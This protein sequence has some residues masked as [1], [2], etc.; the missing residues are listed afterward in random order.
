MIVT[1]E[2]PVEKPQGDRMAAYVESDSLAFTRT[3]KIKA[4]TDAA[5]LKRALESDVDEM[6]DLEAIR[7][8]RK[9]AQ[10]RRR[11]EE[12][13]RQEMVRFAQDFP[14]YPSAIETLDAEQLA[15]YNRLR[16]FI[17]IMR[18]RIAELDR[19]ADRKRATD[20]KQCQAE[21]C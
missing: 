19:A 13:E 10:A 8:Q 12:H 21:A 17:C 16:Y 2:T 9:M 6:R 14:A 20:P 7:D 15:Q 1:T 4:N 18:Q 11:Q 3:A 5:E